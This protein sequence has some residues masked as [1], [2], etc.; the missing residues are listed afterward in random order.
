MFKKSLFYFGMVHYL[1]SDSVIS[2]QGDY[3]SINYKDGKME[4]ERNGKA[5]SMPKIT[6]IPADRNL[7][8]SEA[9]IFK[10]SG[11]SGA[12]SGYGFRVHRCKPC[13]GPR[14]ICNSI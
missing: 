10:I 2:Y 8:S 13:L 9:N 12:L 14:Q 3:L 4:A 7:C 1:K 5:Y 6:Y 11:L